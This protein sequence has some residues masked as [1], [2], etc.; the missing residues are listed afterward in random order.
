VVRELAQRGLD[1][2]GATT[3][4]PALEPTISR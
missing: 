1:A 2:V 4:P 3:P